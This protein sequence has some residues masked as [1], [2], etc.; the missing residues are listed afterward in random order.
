MTFML[1]FDNAATSKPLPEALEE[2]N[3][4]SLSCFGNSSSTHLFGHRASVLLEESR[5]KVLSLLKLQGTHECLFLSG[6]TEANNL[7]IKGTCFRYE[8]RGKDIITSPTE[9]HS[10]LNAVSQL[11]AR[12]DFKEILLKVDEWGN[13][14]MDDLKSKISPQTILVSLMAVNNEIGTI[15]NLNDFASFLKGYPKANFHVDATQAIGKVDL[16]YSKVDLISFSGHKFGGLKGTGCLLYRKGLEFVTQHSGG[17]Q[18][19]GN[20]AGTVDVAGAVSLAKALEITL[21]KQ[22][23]NLQR[24]SE[25]NAYLRQRLSETPEIIFNSPL[26]ASPY[27]LN[28]SLKEHK[29]AIIVEALSQKEIYVSSI[30]AC[31]SKSEET[32]YVLM[33]CHNDKRRANNSIRVS[34]SPDT[35]REQLDLFVEELKG[36]LLSVRPL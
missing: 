28:F 32:S 18:E 33:A 30:S 17:A 10:V 27:V 16:D 6:A 21:S 9:H 14:S 12:F 36:I 8:N 34:F 3:K 5:K 4:V 35:S 22:K 7:A 29:A 19:K 13:P 25:L 24:E 26:E 20:R 31:S 2:Y 15:L 23:E 1:Y 11:A